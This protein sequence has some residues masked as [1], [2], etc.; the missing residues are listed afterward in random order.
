MSFTIIAGSKNKSLEKIVLDFGKKENVEIV[1]RGSVDTMR[2]IAKDNPKCDAVWPVSGIWIFMGD[3][4]QRVPVFIGVKKSLAQQLGWI[5]RDV[6]V[7][8]ILSAIKAK[9]L[10]F[11]MTSAK[12]SNSGSMAYMGFLYALLG[13]PKTIELADLMRDDLKVGM[14]TILSGIHR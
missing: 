10:S 13:N 2:E 5:G 14:R 11:M 12:Q 7:K 1:Y 4:K 8:E 6:R 3:T 9:K